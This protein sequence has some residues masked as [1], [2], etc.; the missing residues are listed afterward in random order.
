MTPKAAGTDIVIIGDQIVGIRR[1]G[2]TEIPSGGFVLSLDED[3]SLKDRKVGF[4][5]ME[6][7][8][9]AIQVGNS[10]VIDGK[11]TEGFISSFYDF[12]SLY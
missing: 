10:A 12:K 5:G 6:Q 8:A 7:Y 11:P 2:N 4:L 1:F 9:F 3:I